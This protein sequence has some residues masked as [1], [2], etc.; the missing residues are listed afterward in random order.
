MDG[1]PGS[2][3]RS[4]CNA[5]ARWPRIPSAGRLTHAPARQA[6]V[7]AS[8]RQT[9]VSDEMHSSAG[10]R[11]AR[12][13]LSDSSRRWHEPGPPPLSARHSRAPPRSNPS[14]ESI[15]P[16]CQS[17]PPSP[18]VPDDTHA[19]D[20][21]PQVLRHPPPSGVP[22]DRAAGVDPADR[23]IDHHVAGHKAVHPDKPGRPRNDRTPRNREPS[24]PLTPDLDNGRGSESRTGNRRVCSSV[25]AGVRRVGGDERCPAGAAVSALERSVVKRAITTPT[26]L[27]PMFGS[28]DS[29]R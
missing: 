3:A 28:T 12:A 14:P 15:K 27:P 9:L 8:A 5:R 23:P 17:L 25:R 7:W 20:Q 2:G 22:K 6:S 29:E 4:L 16:G 24:Q 19:S 1:P 18:P 21:L 11:S 10:V 13:S 26:R